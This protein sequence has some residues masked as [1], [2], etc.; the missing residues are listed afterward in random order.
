MAL[1]WLFAIVGAEHILKMLP[2]GT[3]EFKK[4]I[5]PSELSRYE[6]LAGLDLQDITGMSYNPMTREYKLG[7]N[8]DVNYLVPSPF[9]LIMSRSPSPIPKVYCWLAPK[10]EPIQNT[11]FMSAITCAIF[12]AAKLLA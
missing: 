2:K 8:T 9:A 6:R 7:R 10:P 5:R 1:A 3:H 11:A 4:F 12:R